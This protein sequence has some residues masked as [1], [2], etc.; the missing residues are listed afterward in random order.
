MTLRHPD[1]APDFAA[2]RANL[3]AKAA[4]ATGGEPETG[5]SLSSAERTDE[6]PRADGC[7]RSTVVWRL[8]Y[9]SMRA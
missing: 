8:H 9:R 7:A 2:A 5:C 4:F 1:T 6:E 3:A